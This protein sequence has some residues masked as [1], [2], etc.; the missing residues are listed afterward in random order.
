MAWQRISAGQ[1]I[2]VPPASLLK[3]QVEL[4]VSHWT[5][6]AWELARLGIQLGHEKVVS[7]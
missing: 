3:M 6:L 2:P 4:G 7:H 5:R 1:A